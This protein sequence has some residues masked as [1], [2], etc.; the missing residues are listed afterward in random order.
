MHFAKRWSRA[1][2][3]VTCILA[4]GVSARAPAHADPGPRYVLGVVPS[5]PPLTTHAAWSP[6]VERLSRETGFEI[7]LKVYENMPD[8]EADFASGGPDFIFANPVQAMLAHKAQGY[9]PLVRGNRR[10]AS[11]LFVAQESTVRDIKDLAGKEIAFVGPKNI[12]SILVRQVLSQGD[13]AK[14]NFK[15]Q[16]TGSA[17]NVLKSVQLGKADAGALLE[18][19]FNQQAA[20]SGGG[21]R[22]LLATPP[23]ASHPL[24][25]HPRVP[26]AVRTAVR[27]AVLRLATEPGGPGILAAVRLAAPE[28]ADYDRDYRDLERIDVKGLTAGP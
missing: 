10:I 11:I 2:R 24:S 3:A 28:R 14:L 19:D 15:S 6:F 23:I 8:F 20:A 9:I 25:A 1:A 12:C 22:E 7:T 5:F 21:Y 26:P 4:I 27:E 13:Y 17:S 18:G 16:M